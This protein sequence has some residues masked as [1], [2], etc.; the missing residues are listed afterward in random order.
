MR[1]QTMVLGMQSLRGLDRDDAG[2]KM[3]AQSRFGTHVNC[4]GSLRL[5]ENGDSAA[6]GTESTPNQGTSCVV[7]DTESQWGPIQLD[8]PAPLPYTAN[9][10]AN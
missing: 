1:L 6:T 9:Y 3:P 5:C 7:R 10:T 2:C 4:E 8:P